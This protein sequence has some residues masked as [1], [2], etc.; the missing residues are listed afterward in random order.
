MSDDIVTRLR[1]IATLRGDMSGSI[2]PTACL[3]AAREIELL[4]EELK[5]EKEK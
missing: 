5:K 3:E 2:I 4:R 1:N